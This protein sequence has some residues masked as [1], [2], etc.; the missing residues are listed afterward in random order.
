MLLTSDVSNS[1]VAKTAITIYIFI[2]AAMIYLTTLT[3]HLTM[4]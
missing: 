3:A 4:P 1:A 2:E